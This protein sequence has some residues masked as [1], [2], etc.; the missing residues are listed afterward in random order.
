[1][2]FIG[3]IIKT[4]FLPVSG[5]T[6]IF[7]GF[8]VFGNIDRNMGAALLLFEL[9]YTEQQESDKVP[10]ESIH[11]KLVYKKTNNDSHVFMNNRDAEQCQGHFS[12]LTTGDTKYNKQTLARSWENSKH[13]Q[14]TYC[15]YIH[16]VFFLFARF[17]KYVFVFTCCVFQDDVQTGFKIFIIIFF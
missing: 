2:L 6:C 5:R 11:P 16:I 1:M 8:A 4:R 15:T 17:Y 13:I 9:L 7:L 12:P 3:Y 14:H 10:A